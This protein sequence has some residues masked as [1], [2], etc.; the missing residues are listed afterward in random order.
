MAEATLRSHPCSRFGKATGAAAGWKPGADQHNLC[1]STYANNKSCAADKL[2]A[3]FTGDVEEPANDL[4]T[5]AKGAATAVKDEVGALAVT[6]R[7]HS[8]ATGVTF[9]L[10]AAVTFGEAT[11]SVPTQQSVAI[12]KRRKQIMSRI[13]YIVGRRGTCCTVILRP[14]LIRLRYKFERPSRGVL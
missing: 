5:R 13:I 3:G 7:D 10:V 8:T 11:S 9:A 1:R 2:T 12:F 4:T 6:A 14:Q